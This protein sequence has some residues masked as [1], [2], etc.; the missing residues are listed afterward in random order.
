VLDDKGGLLIDG[1]GAR[2]SEAT[3]VRGS[4]VTRSFNPLGEISNM[5]SPLAKA[6]VSSGVSQTKAAWSQPGI[7]QH[8]AVLG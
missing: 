3:V 5:R 8:T 4:S 6:A 1:N 2:K 7:A